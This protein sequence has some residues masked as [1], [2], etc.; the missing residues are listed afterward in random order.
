MTRAAGAVPDV[1]RHA[2][3]V[4]HGKIR[5]VAAALGADRMEEMSLISRSAKSAIG[6][7]VITTMAV[8]MSSSFELRRVPDIVWP[9]K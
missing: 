4:V 8:P 3:G 1:V 6:S 7:F 9:E 2:A 5:V